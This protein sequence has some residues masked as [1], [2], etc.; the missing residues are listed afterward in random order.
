MREQF[1]SDFDHILNQTDELSERI[2]YVRYKEET[3]H[4]L[5]AIVELREF[6]TDINEGR[7]EIDVATCY[8][9]LEFEPSV[10]DKVIYQNKEYKVM[11]WAKTPYQYK[12]TLKDAARLT[13]THTSGR[14][15]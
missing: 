7:I 2:I 15:R 9:K 6:G 11:D 8:C 3:E 12:L 4:E 13:Y 1:Q 5:N 14:I 10:Y